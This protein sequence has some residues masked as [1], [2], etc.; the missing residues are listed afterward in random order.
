[1]KNYYD[2]LE[3]NQNASEDIIKKV[4]KIQVKKYHPD[5]VPEEKKSV[6]EEKIKELNE[7]YEVL[8][9]QEKKNIYDEELKV[10][11]S[12][13][14]ELQTLKEENSLLKKEI[15]EKTKIITNIIYDYE[16]PHEYP[17]NIANNKINYSLNNFQSPI[18]ENEDNNIAANDYLEKLNFKYSLIDLI[19]KSIVTLILIGLGIYGIY[20]LTGINIITELF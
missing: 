5:I 11:L 13:N 3:I 2:I 18:E 12:N 6:A 19:F 17:S 14:F 16:H 8:S 1:M 10:F 20:L 9:S 7:A 15:E 4:F